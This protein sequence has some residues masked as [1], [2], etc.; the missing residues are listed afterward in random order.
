MLNPRKTKLERSQ[1]TWSRHSRTMLFSTL[2]LCVIA[3]A[4]WLSAT[5]SVRSSPNPRP[6]GEVQNLS[7]FARINEKARAAKG[8]DS[9]AVRELADEIFDVVALAE[10][11]ARSLEEMKDR[12]VRSEINYRN[13]GK[14]A[15]PEKNIVKMINKLADK[16]DL[17]S[18]ARVDGMLVRQ[19]RVKMF[20]QLPNL[21]SLAVTKEE[22]GRGGVG[23]ALKTQMSP[24]EAS[25]LA[26]FLL[27]Q[28]M[29]N[30]SY[31]V[32][33]QEW[34]ANLHQEQMQ[35]WQSFRD[36][37]DS[38]QKGALPEEPPKERL[39]VREPGA[40]GTEMRQT[41]SRAKSKIKPTELFNLANAS[42][43]DLGVGK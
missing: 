37:K 22:N 31:Q 43:D 28:K 30:E 39:S 42:L 21:F 1:L 20:T 3:S 40:R 10:I 14:E 33:P 35:R 41:I 16:L 25:F 36:F 2:L 4:I 32:S 29:I 15:I 38:G 12:I 19:V 11:P 9:T 26:M 18:Y 34:R 7:P 17:P 13:T 8:S 23:S 5:S 6:T 27:Q 24:I